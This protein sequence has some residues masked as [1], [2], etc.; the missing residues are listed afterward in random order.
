[1]EKPEEISELLDKL[2]L[3]SLNLI[4]QDIQTKIN[5]EK[6]ANDGSLHMAK[7]RY[8]QG[9]NSVSL[10]QLPTEN[11]S[12]FNAL[13]TLKESKDD[14]NIPVLELETEKIDKASGFIDPMNWFG[15]LLPQSLYHARDKFKKAIELSIES[16][17]I[18]V[19]LQTINSNIFKLKQIKHDLKE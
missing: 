4:E 3:E 8:I 14:L 10:S 5:I 11:S 7:S 6:L 13:Q 17:N 1:M 2:T 12:E 15:V 19:K 16:A 9:Q 18:R